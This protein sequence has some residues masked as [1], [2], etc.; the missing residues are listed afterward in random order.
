[1]A[2]SVEHKIN[3]KLQGSPFVAFSILKPM[4]GGG[5]AGSQGG[6]NGGGYESK[7]SLIKHTPKSNRWGQSHQ[8]FLTLVPFILFTHYFH[9]PTGSLIST[10]SK[11]LGRMRL[12]LVIDTVGRPI[13]VSQSGALFLNRPISAEL[14]GTGG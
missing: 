11:G 8:L 5:P 10:L 14:G 3:K 2:L 1:M 7:K 12:S 9:V 4:A 6:L 13:H